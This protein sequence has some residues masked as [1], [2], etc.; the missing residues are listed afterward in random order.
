MMWALTHSLS[1][2]SLLNVV[3]SI[4]WYHTVHVVTE[5]SENSL[6]HRS[7]PDVW[8]YVHA[9]RA[10]PWKCFIPAE[11]ASFFQDKNRCANYWNCMYNITCICA[12]CTV[13]GV[14]PWYS[15]DCPFT[16]S[17]VTLYQCAT[18]ELP[19]KPLKGVRKDRKTMYITENQRQ[20]TYV[21]F[22][23]IHHCS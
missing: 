10:I 3:H 5:L 7:I 18:G 22:V 2:L 1:P 20:N 14:V 17:A 11:N 4:V 13:S 23:Q 21:M 9:S 6:G 15:M 8:L 12:V 19:Y 16:V